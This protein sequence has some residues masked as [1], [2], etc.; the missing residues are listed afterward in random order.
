ML[1]NADTTG[2]KNKNLIR[3]TDALLQKNNFF[4]FSKFFLLA[5]WWIWYK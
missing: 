2:P 4:S 3:C 1:P 5:G